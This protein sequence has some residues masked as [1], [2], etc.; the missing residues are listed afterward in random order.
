VWLRLA[1]KNRLIEPKA[2][3]Q[4]RCLKAAGI[5]KHPPNLVTG[6]LGTHR[7][8]FTRMDF[9]CPRGFGIDRKTKPR[10]K[11]HGSEHAQ[12]IL[13][14]ALVRM[15]DCTQDFRGK[16]CAAIDVIDDVTSIRPLKKRVDRKVATLR[17]GARIAE[18]HAR[19]TPTI[20]IF[21][22]L[23]KSRYF[24]GVS[25]VANEHHTKGLAD[26]ARLRENGANLFRCRAGRDIEVL[27]LIAKQKVAN[28]TAR[29][30]CFM[31]SLREHSRNLASRR[32]QG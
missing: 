22:I 9:D 1:T 19:R 6:S 30:Q 11:A 25:R 21:L 16:V 12:S 20:K 3:D 26:A 14:N 2:F 28:A 24:E 5:S 17:I 8:Q 4:T 10:R 13:A 31:P 7:C 32:T 27:R 18:A 23:P 29:E 15:T